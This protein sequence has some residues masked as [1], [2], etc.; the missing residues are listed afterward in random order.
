MP[1]TATY[2]AETVVLI[3]NNR[4]N[5]TRTTTILNPEIDFASFSK[6]TN[7]NSQGTVTTSVVDNDGST[8]VV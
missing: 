8:R 6:P 2:I 3:V 5:D 4:S 7:L 1:I